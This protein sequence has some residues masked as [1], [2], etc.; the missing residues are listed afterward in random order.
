MEEYAEKIKGYVGTVSTCWNNIENDYLGLLENQH[1]RTKDNITDLQ[2]SEESLIELQATVHESDESVERFISI[3]K[4]ST[5][6]ERRLTRAIT[7]TINELEAYLTLTSTMSS[8]IDRIR[9]KSAIT[10]TA[11]VEDTKED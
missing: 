10:I 1:M 8:S 4:K 9:S 5:G 7:L 6:M 2:Q 11:I 3:L